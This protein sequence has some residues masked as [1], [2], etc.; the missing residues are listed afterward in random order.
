M[1]AAG[2]PSGLVV[3]DILRHQVAGAEPD[4]VAELQ[5]VFEAEGVNERER[6]EFDFEGRCF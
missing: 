5:H 2:C 4:V 3:S 1:P 6:V